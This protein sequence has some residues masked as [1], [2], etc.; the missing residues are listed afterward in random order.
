MSYN[1][2]I[3]KFKDILRSG[4]FKITPERLS[5][6]ME[7]ISMSEHFDAEELFFR[8]RRKSKRISRATVYRTLSILQQKGLIRKVSLGKNYSHYEKSGGQIHHEHLICIKCGSVIEF[9]NEEMENIQDEVC[10]TYKFT[11][12]KHSLQ[13]F[14]ICKECS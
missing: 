6:Y 4:G 14:G 8:L 9:V 2:Y 12:I 5:V 11:P 3:G 7:I 13:I 1:S 10:Q